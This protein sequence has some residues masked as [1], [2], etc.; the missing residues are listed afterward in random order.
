M[1]PERRR[2]ARL[3]ARLQ[4]Q[5]KM[6]ERR[7]TN[8]NHCPRKFGRWGVCG[9]KLE[10]I[11]DGNGHV[12][13]VCPACDRMTAGICA[14]CPS[15]VVGTVG[16]ARRCAPCRKL[17]TAQACRECD[18]R[19]R[20]E[21]NRR[22]RE[23][24]RKMEDDKRQ[25]RLT[26]KKDWRAANPDKVAAQKRREGLRQSPERAEYHAKYRAKRREQRAERELERYH[27]NAPQRVCPQCGK[28]P[29]TGRR[30]KCDSCKQATQQAAVEAL[31]LRHGRGRRTDLETT[32]RRKQPCRTN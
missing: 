2:Y 14:D 15:P 27:G 19:H 29:L 23:R 28:T 5:K 6:D 26:Y 9:A 24:Y 7:R 21:Y 20:D 22:G 16:R 30:K 31:H 8:G 32:T 1:T 10:T 17:A 18:A 12:R 13:V 3:Y 11:T 25:R 4:R